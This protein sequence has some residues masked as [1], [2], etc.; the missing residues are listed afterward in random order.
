MRL[1]RRARVLAAEAQLSKWVLLGLP[2]L[3]F[4]VI[5]FLNPDYMKP[6]FTDWRGQVMIF[7]S[8][9]SMTAGGL[10]MDR[11]AKLKY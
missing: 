1:H 3:L 8:V 9:L 5:N 6:F 11:M 10:I 2:A 4:I 7:V